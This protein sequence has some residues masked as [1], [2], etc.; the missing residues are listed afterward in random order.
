M[1]ET[2]IKPPWSHLCY[3]AV[4]LS[5]ICQICLSTCLGSS[6]SGSLLTTS[7][8]SGTG[9]R[10][11]ASNNLESPSIPRTKLPTG[12]QLV[13]VQLQSQLDGV[14]VL[15][16]LLGGFPAGGPGDEIRL[17]PS[18]TPSEAVEAREPC[19]RNGDPPPVR[20]SWSW[21]VSGLQKA[22]S[23]IHGFKAPK[24]KGGG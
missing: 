8:L 18:L 4:Q 21:P 15:C 13:P 14:W 22:G 5:R 3:A 7:R 16:D 11:S 23:P 17:V 12:Y 10:P 2:L 9:G 19:I 20:G 6:R 24:G 1:Y